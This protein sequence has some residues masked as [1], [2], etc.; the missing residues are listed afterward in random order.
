MMPETMDEGLPVHSLYVGSRDGG[1]FQ[2]TDRQAVIKAASSTFDCFTVF[3][4][5]GFFQ[6]RSVATLVIKIASNDR[7]TVEVLGRSLGRLLD[8]QT[9]GWETAGQYQS[10]STG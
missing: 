9:V 5:N 10:I 3:D 2:D 8:Q 7:A 4:A 1:A 6:G